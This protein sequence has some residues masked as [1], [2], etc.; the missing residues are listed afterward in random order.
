[1]VAAMW[2]FTGYVK[3]TLDFLLA[4]FG[5]QLCIPA[6]P[7]TNENDVWWLAPVKL[8]LNLVSKSERS[9]WVSTG[10]C[11]IQQRYNLFGVC[12]CVC[13]VCGV[14]C[15]CVVCGVVMCVC[16]ISRFVSEH[17]VCWRFG[18][19]DL[20]FKSCFQQRNTTCLLS[21]WISLDCARAS[22]LTTANMYI[23]RARCE[24]QLTVRSSGLND[25]WS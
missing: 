10:G 4:G 3:C 24:S 12:V 23:T 19:W 5:V 17:S 14:W 16:V 22:K 2:N 7:L 13:G 15:V 18:V 11:V 9:L 25:R 6:H 8:L 1:M 21:I 20:G